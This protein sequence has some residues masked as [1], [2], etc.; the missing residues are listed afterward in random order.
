MLGPTRSPELLPGVAGLSRPPA[1]GAPAPA[2][3]SARGPPAGNV[4]AHSVP[5]PGLPAPELGFL[6]A[7][8]GASMCSVH[9]KLCHK[10][11]CRSLLS[12]HALSRQRTEKHRWGLHNCRV[13]LRVCFDQ[14]ADSDLRIHYHS[15]ATSLLQLW[16]QSPPA[17]SMICFS[18]KACTSSKSTWEGTVGTTLTSGSFVESKTW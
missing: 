12:V 7:F 13:Q 15:F 11:G 6:G 16:R 2:S 14:K 4:C 10:S 1:A 18:M 9:P 5:M 3:C 17:N 8:L